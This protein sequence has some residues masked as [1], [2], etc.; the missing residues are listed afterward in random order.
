MST[1]YIPLVYIAGPYTAPTDEGIRENIESA[2]EVGYSVASLEA[3]PVV[4]HMN[5]AHMDDLHDQEW[6]LAATMELLMRCDA[7]YMMDNW[8]ESRGATAERARAEQ[9]GIPVF[10]S[11]DTLAT[12]IEEVQSDVAEDDACFGCTCSECDDLEEL[13]V[14]D[15]DDPSDLPN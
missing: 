11:F 4:P 3:M 14:I 2:W 12:W 5:T 10:E 13:L 7:I 6:W 15:E 9:L 8:R 1:K